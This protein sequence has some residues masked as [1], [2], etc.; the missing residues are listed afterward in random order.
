MRKWLK[1]HKS[2]CVPYQLQDLEDG[3]GLDAKKAALFGTIAAWLLLVRT[4]VDRGW[5]LRV[6]R[7]DMRVI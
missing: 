1:V 3:T 2:F 5:L 4:A 7:D 6:C